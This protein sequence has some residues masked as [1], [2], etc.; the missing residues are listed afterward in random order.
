MNKKNIIFA[1]GGMIVGAA[2]MYF[3]MKKYFTNMMESEIA[4]VQ[5][6]Y[7]EKMKEYRALQADKTEESEEE[8]EEVKD[9][10]KSKI[11]RTAKVDAEVEPDYDDIINKLN[12]N[13]FST[14][15]SDD[16]K[17]Y[18]EDEDPYI[19]TC[20]EYNDEVKNEKRECIY[21]SEDEVLIDA[22]TE[23]PIENIDKEV[24]FVNLDK[25]GFG[26]GTEEDEIYIRNNKYGADYHIML[27]M[28]TSYASTQE[29]NGQA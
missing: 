28:N 10:K 2:G 24:G 15:T 25:F 1:L 6:Y 18:K 26:P 13:K 27:E 21:Y 19:I 12:Y 3:G 14:H 11:N 16:I 8:Q 23:E 20:D 29:D 4:D 5:E 7:D 9:E 22:V 17:G